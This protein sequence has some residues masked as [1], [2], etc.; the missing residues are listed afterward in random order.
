M[1]RV[2]G[3]SSVLLC[4]TPATVRVSE[5]KFV[6]SPVF[7]CVILQQTRIFGRSVVTLG[8]AIPYAHSALLVSQRIFQKFA[9]AAESRT[10]TQ[11]IRGESNLAKGGDSIMMK[12][13]DLWWV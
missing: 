2:T 8:R 3:S 11:M 4:G 12:P 9:S 6:D 13:S 5:V 1:R 7:S 10:L